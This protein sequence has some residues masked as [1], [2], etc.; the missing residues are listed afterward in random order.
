M[1]AG[2]RGWAVG[3]PL[4]AAA[5]GMLF[6]MSAGAARGS[7]LRGTAGVAL[8]YLI[9]TQTRS[10]EGKAA[11]VGALR[12]EVDRLTDARSA[13]DPQLAAL[14]AQVDHL[15]GPAGTTPVRGQAVTVELSDA[16][17]G[18]RIPDGYTVDDVVVHQQD[19]QAVV[20]ALWAAGA[21]AMTIQDQRVIATSAVRCVGNTLILQG[22]VYSPPYVITAIGDIGSLRSG[23]DSDR[24]VGIYRGYV[25][26]V[27]LGYR[28]TDSAS[29]T[30]PGY[31][32][33]LELRYARAEEPATPA[34]RSASPSA[35]S[36]I[37]S[38]VSSS[39]APS[40]QEETER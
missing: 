10:V 22:R 2:R 32:G 16:R 38:S 6:A 40:A 39:V 26:K 4:V 13:A 33:G 28:V 14:G 35:S 31:T 23:L 34:R 29:V 25:D 18:G 19:V 5:A 8:P 15:A 9:R 1:G 27:G 17:T 20:N 30:M 21:E 24:A 11:Q 12:S 37:S 7:D 3:V 36:S